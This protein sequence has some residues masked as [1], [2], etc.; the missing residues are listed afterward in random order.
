MAAT[1]DPL[2]VAQA[3]HRAGRDPET[4]RRWIRTGKLPARKTGGRYVMDGRDLAAL[5]EPRS[6]PAPDAWLTFESGAPQ[7]D[8]VTAIRASRRRI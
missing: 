3:A 4:I 7:P 8:W 5:V 6:L 1:D 2:T